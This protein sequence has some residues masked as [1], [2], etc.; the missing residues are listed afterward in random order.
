MYAQ[1]EVFPNAPLELVAIE[2]RFPYAPRLRKQATIDEILQDLSVE[3]PVLN[4]QQQITLTLNEGTIGQQGEVPR[5]FNLQSTISAIIAP[6]AVTIET[7][8]YSDFSAFKELALKIVSSVAKHG[9]VAAS[10]RIGLRYIDEIRV[11]S[12]IRDVRDWGE[13]VSPEFIG[14]I[15]VAGSHPATSAQGQISYQLS[16][17]NMHLLFRYAAVHGKGVIGNEPLRRKRVFED[18][19]PIFV[20]DLD[21]FYQPPLESAPAFNPIDVGE[22]LDALHT[23]AGETFQKVITDRLRDLFREQPNV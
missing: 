23:P 9:S 8:N 15:D 17:E 13:W 10:E 19:Q 22:V 11:P 14:M 3:L 1:R 2:V 16:Q 5:L 21:A 12:Q 4:K 18:A 20:I 6:T 7:T